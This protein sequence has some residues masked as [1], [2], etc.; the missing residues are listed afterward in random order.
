ME[1]VLHF[2]GIVEIVFLT[3]VSVLFFLL[4]WLL[5]LPFLADELDEGYEIP[6]SN[7]EINA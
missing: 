1:E 6:W 7:Y 5:C 2:C 3:E 4:L